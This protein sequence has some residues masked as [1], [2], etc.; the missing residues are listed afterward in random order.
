MMRSNA[1]FALLLALA[2]C[3][4]PEAPITDP[5]KVPPLTAEQ[6]ETIKQDDQRTQEEE[7]GAFLKVKAKYAAQTKR[8]G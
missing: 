6:L 5:S 2:G 7:G 3:G 1:I 8:R 4:G